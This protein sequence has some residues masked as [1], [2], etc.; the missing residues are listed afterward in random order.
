MTKNNAAKGK[1]KARKIVNNNV[2]KKNI[3]TLDFT[4]DMP[5]NVEPITRAE[6][7]AMRKALNP[8][9]WQRIK[10]WFSRN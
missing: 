9:I 10:G 8:T 1:G 5:T 6:I 4:T 3:V 7:E 2:E